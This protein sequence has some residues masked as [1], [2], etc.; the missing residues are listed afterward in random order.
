MSDLIPI[1]ECPQKTLKAV[2]AVLT[3]IDDTLSLHGRIPAEA[4]ASLEA[5]REAGLA[6]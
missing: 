2:K 1:E 6:V 3:D 4:Y 5:L